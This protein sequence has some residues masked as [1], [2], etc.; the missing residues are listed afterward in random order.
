MKND[1]YVVTRSTNLILNYIAQSAYEVA[2]RRGYF[3][4]VIPE[5]VDSTDSYLYYRFIERLLKDVLP[6]FL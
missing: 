4:L 2:R 6:S 1:T 3:R 5:S